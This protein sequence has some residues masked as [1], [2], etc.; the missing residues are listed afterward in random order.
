VRAGAWRIRGAI[1]AGSPTDVEPDAMLADSLD[2]EM[3][4]GMRLVGMEDQGEWVPV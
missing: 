2:D 3:C 4:V 1:R